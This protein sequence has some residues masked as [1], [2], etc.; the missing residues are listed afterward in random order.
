MRSKELLAAARSQTVQYMLLIYVDEAQQAKLPPAAQEALMSAYWKFEE[1]LQSKP[2]VRIAGEA[3]HPV[4]TAKTIRERNGGAVI[5]DGPFAE[6]KEQLGGFYLLDVKDEAEALEYAKQIPNVKDGSI[7]VRA[8][9]VFE[10]P[11]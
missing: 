3:L 2:G 9:M 10:Q 8:V 5:T 11:S 6:T 4:A 1:S 7:E